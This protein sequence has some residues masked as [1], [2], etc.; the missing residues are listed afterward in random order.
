[1][2]VWFEEL[3]EPVQFCATPFDGEE[4]GRELW[5]RAMKGEYG[6]I[7]ILE[8]SSPLTMLENEQRTKLLEAREQQKLLEYHGGV[9]DCS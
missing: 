2:L 9:D 7:E 4:Y 6:E 1:M 5:F 3:S 8:E